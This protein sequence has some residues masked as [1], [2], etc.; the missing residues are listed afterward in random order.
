MF[1]GLDID[2]KGA[3]YAATED[4][5]SFTHGRV[6][7]DTFP[8]LLETHKAKFVGAEYTGRLAEL[9]ML[10]S[11]TRRRDA[12]STMGVGLSERST[13]PKS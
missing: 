1:I 11:M 5:E 2:S 12:M 6:T 7:L 10:A 13:R 8:A 3:H 9:W 4:G